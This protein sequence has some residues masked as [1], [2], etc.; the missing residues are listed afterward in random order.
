VQHRV[1]LTKQRNSDVDAALQYLVWALE[2]VEI[3]GHSKAA[4]HA[5]RAIKALSKIQPREI[6]DS[7]S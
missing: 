3:A 2:H 7:A 6:E 4:D 5:R 1:N